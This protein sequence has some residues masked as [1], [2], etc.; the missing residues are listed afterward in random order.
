MRLFPP[1]EKKSIQHLLMDLYRMDANISLR[2]VQ[3][4]MHCILEDKY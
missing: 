1:M 4:M 3:I 2:K